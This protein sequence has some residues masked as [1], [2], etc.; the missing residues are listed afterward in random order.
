MGTRAFNLVSLSSKFAVQNI[1]R[2]LSASTTA[3]TK[4]FSN[5]FESLLGEPKIKSPYVNKLSKTTSASLSS[6]IKDSDKPKIDVQ[7]AAA[8]FNTPHIVTADE[9]T[10]ATED[11]TGTDKVEEALKDN[12]ASSKVKPIFKY[13]APKPD[14]KDSQKSDHHEDETVDEAE[15]EAK[16]QK[17]ARTTML[18]LK[19]F[20]AAALLSLLSAGSYFAMEGRDEHGN[21]IPDKHSGQ[22]FGFVWRVISSFEGL[23]KMAFQPSRDKFLPEPLPYPYVQPKYTLVIEMKNI[24]L[25]PE[26]TYKTGYRFKKRPAVDYFIDQIGYP[27]FEIVIYTSESN[28]SAPSIIEQLDPKQKIMYKLFRDCTIYDKGH[29]RKDLSRLNRDLSKV[30]YIDFDPESF[31][32]HPENVLRVPKWDGD[33]EDTSLMDLAELLKTILESD[34]EDVRPTLQ[35][36]SQYDDPA[37]EFRRRAAHLAEQKGETAAHSDESNYSALKKYSGKL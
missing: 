18:T 3:S 35:Y 27:N 10:T 28:M 24:L 19:I 20:S 29:H 7:N 5:G 21:P 32:L 15:K 17:Q 14:D 2:S 37:K 34:V 9:K 13:T 30:I 11:L 23:S 25:A 8:T 16:R 6:D 12:E 26:W 36:Y 31:K 4:K 33:M 22:T 1:I